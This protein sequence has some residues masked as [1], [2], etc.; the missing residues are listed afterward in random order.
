M[1]SDAAY[2][3]NLAAQR[4]QASRG[5]SALPAPP[6]PPLM[7]VERIFH[8]KEGRGD[9]SYAKNST[10]QRKALEK[11]KE[12]RVESIRDVYLSTLPE[13]MGVADLGCS[14][15]PN[16]FS[17]LGDLVGAVEE[18]CRKIKRRPP[19]FR[20]FLNDLPSNDFN[21]IFAS[22]PEFYSRVLNRGGGS[23]GM[24]EVFVAAVAGSF[25]GRLFPR[26][27][28]HFVHSSFGLHWLSQV[29]PELFD[30][31][32]EKSINKG[33]IYIS[34]TS[35]KK[36]AEAYSMQFQKDFTLFLDS[37]SVELIPG[38]Q[39]VLMALGRPTRD[40]TNTGNTIYWELLSQAFARMVSMGEIEEDKVESYKT[41]F[42]APSVDEIQELVQKEGSFA[43]DRL[44][45]F[46]MG[47]NYQED[48]GKSMAAAVRAIQE[49][50][51]AHHF[52]Q[53]ILDPLFQIYAQLLD[54]EMAKQEIKAF[55]L[56][57]ILRKLI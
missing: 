47:G 49:T 11:V 22:L 30:D 27:S 40:H 24:A 55:A 23:D 48:D 14:S 38:G 57:L 50:L 42:Y 18:K 13:S 2:G 20:L 21:S 37:R 33:K 26:G 44:D 41:H 31:R 10:N 15:G 28:L 56:L 36:V 51:I 52:G 46:E 32:T 3:S 29:P 35:P 7:D 4:Y 1:G 6:P 16:T 53:A 9:T 34:D 8:M 19:E 45:T 12:W 17:V 25:Y 5:G 54:E 43:V 39:M